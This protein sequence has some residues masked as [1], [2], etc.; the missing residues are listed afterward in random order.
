MTGANN[1]TVAEGAEAPDDRPTVVAGQLPS[2][3]TIEAYEHVLPDSADRILAM[4]EH[5]SAHR[6]DMEGTLVK[7]AAR[8]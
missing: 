1:A 6:M 7:A 8:T 3:E 5:Q 2:A 4:L